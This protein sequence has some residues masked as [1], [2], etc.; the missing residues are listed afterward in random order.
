MGGHAVGIIVLNVG[1]P[2]LPGNVANATTFRYPVRYRVVEGAG[3]ASLLGGDGSLLAP[4]LAAARALVDDGCHAIVGACGYF[5]RFQREMAE[6]LDVPVFLSSL[7]QVPL[8]TRGLR[9]GERLGILC[10]SAPSLDRA[11]LEAVGI[12]GDAPLA[13]RGMETSSEF[14]TSILEGKGWMDDAAVER[15]VVD[16]AMALV[17]EHPEVSALLLECSDMPPYAH[18]VQRAT[19]L[20]VWDF[21]TLIDW[22]A[23]GVV[24]RP[25]EGFV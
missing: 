16:A 25:F 21:T 6:G 2:L 14:R 7:L 24:R 13:I 8:L 10:A 9:R 20:P 11:A 18:A 3:V 4:S 12:P 23:S 17:H 1:Y 19:G 15:E 22:I 5:A